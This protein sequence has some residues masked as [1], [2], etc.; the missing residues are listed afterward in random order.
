M[1]EGDLLKH[2]DYLTQIGFPVISEGVQ[3]Q[4]KSLEEKNVKGVKSNMF[5]DGSYVYVRDS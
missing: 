2:V 1:S 3:A 4:Q 5:P